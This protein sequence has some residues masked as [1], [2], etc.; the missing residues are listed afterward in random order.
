MEVEP[1]GRRLAW[2]SSLLRG[3]AVGG[4]TKGKSKAV[5]C[6][7]ATNRITELRKEVE[8]GL[9]LGLVRRPLGRLAIYDG[10]SAS[11]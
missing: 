9:T 5:Q 3:V 2:P 8:P 1:G 10:D 4:G 6:R 11:G 7:S